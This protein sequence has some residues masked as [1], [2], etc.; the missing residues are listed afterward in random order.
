MCDFANGKTPGYFIHPVIRA[1]ILHFWLAYDH[2]FR[3]GNGRT[4][5]SLFYWA[6]LHYGYWLAEYISISHILVKA[7]SQYSRSFL[8]T[9][10]D[11]NDLSYFIAHQI[12]VLDQ[13]HRQLERY[14]NE[15]VEKRRRLERSMVNLIA[16]N[17]RQQALISHA[18]R[19]PGWVYTIGSHKT[20]HHV[21]YQTARTD[22][23][24]LAEQ[25][26][27]ISQKSG[28][29]WQFCATPDIEIRLKTTK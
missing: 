9:E 10:T 1:I 18:L 29:K 22:L 11:D 14:L 13:A 28:K 17:S 4:A 6:M 24:G 19:H 20:I 2:P 7:P 12:S 3:D 21:S 23:L 27:F 26:L 5:R 25:R 15:Q 16:F 8:Y